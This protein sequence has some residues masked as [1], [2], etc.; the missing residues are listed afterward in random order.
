[1]LIACLIAQHLLGRIPEALVATVVRL[2]SNNVTPIHDLL[3]T[4]T[5]VGLMEAENLVQTG[6]ITE[7][8]IA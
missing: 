8:E 4:T 5:Q 6:L 7:Q 1:M 2:R 3:L